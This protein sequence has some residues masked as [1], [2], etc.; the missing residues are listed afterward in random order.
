MRF[1][2]AAV[3]AFLVLTFDFD[4]SFHPFSSSQTGTD[5]VVLLQ[6]PS[7][8]AETPSASPGVSEEIDNRKAEENDGASTELQSPATM[9]RNDF[10]RTLQEAA[11]ASGI[12]VAFF[13]RLI[14]QES[15]F[16]LSEVS[17]AG[18][19]GVA[20]FMPGT[21]AEV[22]LVDPF[23][24]LTAL[25]ASARLLRQLT[26]EFG[27]LGLAAAAYNAGRGRV[28]KWLSRASDLPQETRDYVRIITGNK[29]ERWIDKAQIVAMR[30]DLPREAPCEGFG[31]LSREKEV[32]LVPVSL[33]PS[34][35]S[36]VRKAEAEQIAAAKLAERRAKLRRL[37]LALRIKRA[38]AEDGS[39]HAKVAMAMSRSGESSQA[40]PR[41]AFPAHAPARDAQRQH[42]VRVASAARRASRPG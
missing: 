9:T 31:G 38:S 3:A 37:A 32:T 22:G 20:Q 34:A 1:A 27:N 23:D 4:G 29:A 8:E 26:D 17:R 11:E 19:L 33:A 16:N 36:L 40:K 21:A 15:R 7:A 13:A 12:P 24:P 14:W 2:I 30:L 6:S 28:Q 39:Q 25:P 35:D 18:A 41:K 5:R 42:A 10:C